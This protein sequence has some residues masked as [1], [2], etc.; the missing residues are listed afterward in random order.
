M[1]RSHRIRIPTSTET[2][3]RAAVEELFRDQRRGRHH[4]E[5]PKL[6]KDLL[7]LFA[8]VAS[9]VVGFRCFGGLHVKLAKADAALSEIVE[10]M[11]D[12]GMPV[13]ASCEIGF[14]AGQFV[15]RK[16][17]GSYDGDVE[18]GDSIEFKTLAALRNVEAEIEGI[19]SKMDSLVFCGLIANL[20]TLFVFML[21][22]V[23][24]ARIMES[25]IPNDP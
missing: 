5:H 14:E 22:L 16:C 6:W 11:L 2:E 1:S 17:S 23:K 7:L 21:A 9:L 3:L 19:R 25:K 4:R 10:D 24:C 8:L 20:L 15:R 18:D 13:D 12:M